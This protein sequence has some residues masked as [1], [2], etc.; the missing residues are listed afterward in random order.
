M[1]GVRLFCLLFCHRVFNHPPLTPLSTSLTPDTSQPSIRTPEN[2]SYQQRTEQDP[3]SR[4]VSPKDLRHRTNH[5][6]L[7]PPIPLQTEPRPTAR[8]DWNKAKEDRGSTRPT[9]P[10][11]EKTETLA[12]DRPAYHP[13]RFR[14]SP[15][16]LSRHPAS[17][18]AGTG[19]DCWRDRSPGMGH[20][21]MSHQTAYGDLHVH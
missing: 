9:P 14:G 20:P 15:Q 10:V 17:S 13:S 19:R 11:A 7:S 16:S 21:N 4:L 5:S 2:K 12:G 3:F 1:L 8:H 18:Q 6:H